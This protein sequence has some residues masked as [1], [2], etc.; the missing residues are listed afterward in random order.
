[1]RSGEDDAATVIQMEDAG[2]SIAA[3]VQCWTE[4]GGEWSHV[5]GGKWFVRG[6]ESGIEDVESVGDGGPFGKS[7]IERNIQGLR[8]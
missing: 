6:A 7:L 8:F 3:E 1:M 2:N 4:G 5:V